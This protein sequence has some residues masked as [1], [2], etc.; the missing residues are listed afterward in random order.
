M[1][2]IHSSDGG[3]SHVPKTGALAH[4]GAQPREKTTRAPFRARLLRG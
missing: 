3:L 4:T 1:I 2:G